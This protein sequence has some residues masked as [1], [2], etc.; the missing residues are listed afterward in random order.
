MYSKMT[1]K[2]RILSYAEAINEAHHLA[3]HAD[4]RVYVMGQGVDNPWCVGTSTRDLF[5]T[6]GRRR[7]ID[8][9]I[10]ENAMTGAAIGSAMAGMRPIVFHPRMDFMYLAMDQIIN[11]C[12]HW[13]YMFGGQVNVPV[14]VR[15]I[16]N[17]GNEQ[18]AQHSQSPYSMYAHVPGIKVVVPGTPYDA[19]GLLLAAISD[20]NPVLYIDDR[21][22]YETKGPVPE[23]A[24]KTPIGKAAVL[25][26]GNDVTVVAV[27]YLVNESLEAAEILERGGVSAEVIDVRTV[28][29][30]D[31]ETVV[32]SVKKTGRLVIADPAWPVCGIASELNAHVSSK[33]FGKLRSPV[34]SV[35]LPDA[36]APAS[37]SLEKGYY[38]DE[39]NIVDAVKKTI[40]YNPG[41]SHE[42]QGPVY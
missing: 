1:D 28:K 20:D 39:K 5:E 37:V 19:K 41:V 3:L 21:W 13:Y 36:P 16:I 18:A 23:G 25:K 22:L 31:Y 17:R 27:S 34:M 30:L 10:S 14:T 26:E 12:A 32:S 40:N 8:V 7:V 33:L 2:E 42:V 11:H 6:F 9:P 24:Y 15:G 29:P 35:T 4:E 38:P